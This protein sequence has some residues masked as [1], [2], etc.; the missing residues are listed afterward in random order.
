LNAPAFGFI[1]RPVSYEFV[2]G[3]YPVN[4]WAHDFEGIRVTGG[5]EDGVE[6][7]VDG[8]VLARINNDAPR[9]DVPAV[10]PRV[11]TQFVGFNYT[12]DT[13]R[14][15]DGE[16]DLVVYVVDGALRR[17]EIGRQKIVVDNNT[18]TKQ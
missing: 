9:P 16:H 6:I 13:T 2:Q 17:S 3:L 8:Q 4:G 5:I 1:D 7:D 18:V 11:T 14:L 10:D 15:T 12:L